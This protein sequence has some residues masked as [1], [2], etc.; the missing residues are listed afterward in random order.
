MFRILITICVNGI[1]RIFLKKVNI[2]DAIIVN[3][4]DNIKMRLKGVK[5]KYFALALSIM[6]AAVLGLYGCSSNST[7]P[8]D[9]LKDLTLNLNNMNSNVGQEITIRVMSSDNVLQSQAIINVLESADA[10]I[11]IPNI[12]DDG[13]YHIDMFADV[14]DN[15][16]YDPPPTDDAWRIDIPASGIVNFSYNTNV[17][18]ISMPAFAA[19]GNNFKLNLLNFV[20]EVGKTMELRVIEGSEN[21]T[22]GAYRFDEIP[23]IV[24]TVEIPGII[25]D[26]AN[27]HIDFY[28]DMNVNN[29]YDPP[30]E[31]EAWSVSQ[32]GTSSGLSFT[33]SHNIDWT[34]IHF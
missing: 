26:G 1:W 30:P 12:I 29:E 4:E 28:I 18:D 11:T 7:G 14:N 34:D 24:F 13:S 27:Y 8:S 16:S 25:L 21:R 10:S 22:V 32:K 19:R 20:D 15:G 23:N 33:F 9:N 6:I 5:M 31:D 3:K 2:F 17:A